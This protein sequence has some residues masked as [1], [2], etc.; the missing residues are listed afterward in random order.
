MR[1]VPEWVGKTDDAAV[2]PRVRLRVW[3]LHNGVCHISLRKIMPGD[4]WHLDHILPLADGGQH[5]ES[6][7]APALSKPHRIKTRDEARLRAKVRRVAKKHLGI[8]KSRSPMPFG[9]GSPFKRKVGG[10]VVLRSREGGF[11]RSKA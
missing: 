5:R 3:E 1:T 4:E 2:P 8:N 11:R 9:K 6:N 7:L 10:G